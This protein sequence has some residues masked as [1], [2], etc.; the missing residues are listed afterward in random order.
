MYDLMIRTF[1][2]I[3]T[4]YH[5][6]NPC[7]TTSVLT[8]IFPGVIIGTT[9]K[10]SG[11]MKVQHA[12]MLS[13]ATSAQLS[14]TAKELKRS[15]SSIVEEALQEYFKNIPKYRPSEK[16][17]RLITEEVQEF[18]YAYCTKSMYSNYWIPASR[19]Y[20]LYLIWEEDKDV[21]YLS[22]KDFSKNMEAL[23]YKKRRYSKGIV[24]EGITERKVPYI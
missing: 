1:L 21:V 24:W 18:I 23:G 14:I 20:E 12:A 10:G 22:I 17:R 9:P 19:L 16:P 4:T 11:L 15:K 5:T 7:A 6:W 13:Q 8:F 2:K 3:A